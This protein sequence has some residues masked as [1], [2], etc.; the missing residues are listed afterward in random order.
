MFI[1]DRLNLANK[2]CVSF[3]SNIG[4]DIVYIEDVDLLAVDPVD[5]VLT[6]D[7][8][9]EIKESVNFKERLAGKFAAKESIMKVLEKGLDTIDLIEI[10]ILNNDLG[11]PLVYLHGK[12]L[13]LWKMKR[14]NHLNVSISHHKKYAVAIAIAE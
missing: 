13:D 9:E 6:R 14:F 8:W 5:I 11:R 10:E 1:K 7:E 3:Q 2:E 4:I 12:T